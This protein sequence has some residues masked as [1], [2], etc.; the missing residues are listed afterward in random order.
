MLIRI[1]LR[2]PDVVVARKIEQV[3]DQQI[4]VAVVHD[5]VGERVSLEPAQHGVARRPVDGHVIAGPGDGRVDEAEVERDRVIAEAGVDRR[6]AGRRREAVVSRRAGRGA[7][8]DVQGRAD[9]AAERVL[10]GVADRVGAE[11][12]GGRRVHI[13]AV[14]GE[15][16]RAALA[17][18]DGAGDDGRGRPDR[19]RS[20][21]RPAR[22]Q[23]S[24]SRCRQSPRYR[25][26]QRRDR[27]PLRRSSRSNAP[28]RWHCSRPRR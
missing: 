7:D 4:A 12:E 25:R 6:V 10:R 8:I 17:G 27:P 9:L 14:G 22:P 2:V 28:R 24:A 3:V 26:A 21:A 1:G 23:R 11:E 16:D 5:A 18:R 15:L 13:G 20:R 19:C